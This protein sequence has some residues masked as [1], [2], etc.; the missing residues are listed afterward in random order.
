M[1]GILSRVAVTERLKAVFTVLV[2][3]IYMYLQD[4]AIFYDHSGI[5]NQMVI[6]NLTTDIKRTKTSHASTHSSRV[7]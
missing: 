6:D 3:N 5:W 7:N 4:A 2:L 1:F